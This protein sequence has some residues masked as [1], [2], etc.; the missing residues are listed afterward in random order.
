MKATAV[1]LIFAMTLGLTFGSA[2][3]GQSAGATF[4]TAK[5]ETLV[6]VPIQDM[7]CEDIEKMLAR[8]DATRYRGHAP[9]PQNKADAPLFEY[10]LSLSE[11]NYNRCALLKK[12]AAGGLIIMQRAQSE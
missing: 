3:H 6:L 7:A 12:K 10:E 11:A 5:G 4:T 2:A 1:R 8:I 9:T